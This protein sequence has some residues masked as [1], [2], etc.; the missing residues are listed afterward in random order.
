MRREAPPTDFA[1]KTELIEVLRLIVGNASRQHFGLPRRGPEFQALQLPD[2]LQCA[3]HSMKLMAGSQVLPAIEECQKLRGGDGLNLASKFAYSQPMNTGQQPSMAPFDF[4]F[5]LRFLAGEAAAQ[6]L[7]L[8]FELSQRLIH[9]VARHR[10]FA[11][12]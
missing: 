6:D 11:R 3:I 5:T 8:G 9:Q 7:A 12:K 2:D 4:G 10:Q 1:G